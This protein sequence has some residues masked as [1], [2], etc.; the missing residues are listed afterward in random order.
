MSKGPEMNPSETYHVPLGEQKRERMDELKGKHGREIK[1]RGKK[2]NNDVWVFGDL[3]RDKDIE[4]VAIL[5]K[6][7]KP[8]ALSDSK[9]AETYFY[10]ILMEVKPET[11][12][13][14]TGLKD[15]NGV[16]IFEGDILGLYVRG[17]GV[18]RFV[19]EIGTVI[20]DVISR[21]GFIDKIVKVAITGVVFNWNGYQLLP[22]VDAEGLSDSEKMEVIGNKWDNPELMAQG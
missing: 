12:G 10:F 8:Y 5:K 4:M 18:R 13:Q 15:K 16:E 17:E 1:F 6:S 14:F 9:E 2:V 11:V 22:C 19:V 20:R 21:H 7:S 3:C